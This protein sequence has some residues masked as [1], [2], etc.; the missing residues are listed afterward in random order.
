MADGNAPAT[1][2]APKVETTGTSHQD[3]IIVSDRGDDDLHDD[4]ASLMHPIDGP[5]ADT[6]FRVL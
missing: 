5:Y 6:P 1:N 4:Y 3:W 2:S